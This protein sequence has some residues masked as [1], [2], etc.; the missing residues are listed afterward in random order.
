MAL[1]DRHQLFQAY[2]NHGSLF[3]PQIQVS[4]STIF[5]PELYDG[6][7]RAAVA[8]FGLTSCNSVVTDKVQVRGTSYANGMLVL[9]RYTKGQVQFEKI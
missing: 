3:S 9:L 4:N 8:D 6:G 1:D 2:Q 7:L 5:Y